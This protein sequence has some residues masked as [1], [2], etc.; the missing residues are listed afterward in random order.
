MCSYAS[1]NLPVTQAA[2]P[3]SDLSPS[4]PGAHDQFPPPRQFQGAAEPH[5]L[6]P[7]QLTRTQGAHLPTQST[8]SQRYT[9][10]LHN[11]GSPS[12]AHRLLY[13]E[14]GPVT[15]KELLRGT[16]SD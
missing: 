15:L 11:G 7:F 12:P 4:F 5:T 1:D 16:G 14:G 8:C 6:L 2:C 10:S 3:V 13:P 9:P